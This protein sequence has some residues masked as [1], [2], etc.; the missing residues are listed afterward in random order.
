M[1]KSTAESVLLFFVP[2]DPLGISCYNMALWQL[3]MNLDQ[4]KIYESKQTNAVSGGGQHQPLDVA[5]FHPL[6]YLASH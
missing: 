6:H 1:P 2:L 4:R 3:K 5:L